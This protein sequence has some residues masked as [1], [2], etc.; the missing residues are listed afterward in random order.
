MPRYQ[1]PAKNPWYN[2]L[3]YLHALPLFSYYISFSSS[4]S[5]LSLSP[6]SL[7]HQTSNFR[8]FWVGQKVH[9]DFSLTYCFYG[10]AWMNFL[11]NPIYLHKN[12]NLPGNHLWEDISLLMDFYVKTFIVYNSVNIY[13]FISYLHFFNLVLLQ[14]SSCIITE[15]CLFFIHIVLRPGITLVLTE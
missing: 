5:P 3:S 4:L 15:S 12:V 11:V 6:L 8:L 2:F 13:F 9:S 1:G 14:N 7:H 10:K